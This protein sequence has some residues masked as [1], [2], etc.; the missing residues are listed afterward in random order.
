MSKLYFMVALAV[1]TSFLLYFLS[2]ISLHSV[3]VVFILNLAKFE[4]KGLEKTKLMFPFALSKGISKMA[5]LKQA[6]GIL[7]Q[8]F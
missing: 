5:E 3:M 4:R 6:T 1:E 2:I 8:L 7:L